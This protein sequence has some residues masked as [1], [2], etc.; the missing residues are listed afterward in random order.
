MEISLG[1]V[2]DLIMELDELK[3]N[4]EEM[5]DCLEDLTE[6]LR[7]QLASVEN[8]KDML[9]TASQQAEEHPSLPPQSTP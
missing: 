6:T 7:S 9:V 3:N 1:K 5:L 2:A 4:A 8:M